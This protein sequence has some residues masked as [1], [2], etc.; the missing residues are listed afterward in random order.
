M[1]FYNPLS[2][3]I[4]WDPVV[5]TYS[6]IFIRGADIH[7]NKLDGQTLTIKLSYEDL[8]EF[9]FK[10]SDI[11]FDF[12]T[13]RGKSNIYFYLVPI[14]VE[15]YRS[16]RIVPISFCENDW[17]LVIVRE[18]ACEITELIISV[19]FLKATLSRLN[20]IDYLINERFLSL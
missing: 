3:Q 7:H 6:H 8:G 13:Y 14:E 1:T 11:E 4:T 2:N 15:S 17:S 20:S 12:H 5:A 18:E 9:G 16:I 10:I 19:Q